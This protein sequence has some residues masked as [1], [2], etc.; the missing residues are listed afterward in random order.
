MMAT[1]RDHGIGLVIIYRGVMT[2]IAIPEGEKGGGGRTRI[3]TNQKRGAQGT[4][5]VAVAG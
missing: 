5:P 4:Y 3:G 2:K 1:A